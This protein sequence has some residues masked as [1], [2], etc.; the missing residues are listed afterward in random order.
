MRNKPHIQDGVV[1]EFN[2]MGHCKGHACGD[3]VNVSLEVVYHSIHACCEAPVL[4]AG[5]LV[6]ANHTVNLLLHFS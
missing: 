1:F 2:V 6:S 5:A 4:H 3:D